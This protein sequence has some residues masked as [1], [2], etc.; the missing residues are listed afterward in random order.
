MRRRAHAI[1]LALSAAACTPSASSEPTIVIGGTPPAP[2]PPDPAPR[3]VLAVA[4]AEPSLG[5]TFR[6]PRFA[7]R[8]PR[9]LQLLIVEV[10]N[11][12]SL[13]ATVAAGNPDRPK[14]MRRLA[15]EYVELARVAQ[16]EGTPRSMKT[17]DAARAMA[18]RYYTR[19]KDEYPKWCAMPDASDPSKSTGCGDEVL[20]YLAYE[21]EQAG[22][23]DHARRWY[24]EVVQA[25]PSSRLVPNTYLAFGELFFAEGDADPS[26]LKF[27]EMS[28]AE[29][30]KYPPPENA[31]YGYAQYQLGRVLAR[32]REF[33]EA[34]HAFERALL[35]C[36]QSANAPGAAALS[37]AAKAALAE[38]TTQP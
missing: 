28:Y 32:K 37:R 2:A 13:F 21:H 16:H 31:V 34:A 19:L 15:E 27:A 33:V 8:P 9:P 23:L 36:S 4:K 22:D 14:L 7:A 11:L 6:D 29:A 35:W 24:L 20:Y 38:T 3:P 12:E 1:L 18:I 25:W 30:V 17:R 10:Q 5:E 26:K